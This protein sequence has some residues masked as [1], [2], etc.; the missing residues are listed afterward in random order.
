M[1]KIKPSQKRK[2]KKPVSHSNILMINKCKNEIKN[3]TANPSTL[4]NFANELNQIGDVRGALKIYK[5]GLK[6][7]PNDNAAL[8]NIALILIALF[9]FA[10]AIIY[11]T[12]A[13]T[14]T[15]QQFIAYIYRSIAYLGERKKAEAYADF[16]FVYDNYRDK[17][18]HFTKLDKNSF[19]QIDFDE[20]ME[21]CQYPAAVFRPLNT[22]YFPTVD[23]PV[24]E[25][26]LFKDYCQQ[27]EVCPQNDMALL[28]DII[29]RENLSHP[30][31]HHRETV[32]LDIDE[33][34][35]RRDT[36]LHG[37]E[38]ETA[39]RDAILHGIDAE[40]AHREAIL[41]GIDAEMAKSVSVKFLIIPLR[42]INFRKPFQYILNRIINFRK[43]FQY[44]LNLKHR[45]TAIFSNIFLL[46][47]LPLIE[48]MLECEAIIN[49]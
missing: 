23:C 28:E 17:I 47:I 38:A 26:C 27:K 8:I 33:V 12:K 7:S 22:S 4:F 11:L 32:L 45:L 9:D 44:I 31:D 46:L 34:M 6:R 14:H 20:A 25:I 18:H 42:L 24:D 16:K 13:I 41:H 29:L 2:S 30:R 35:D 5:K 19:P 43:P 21:Y 10:Q 40:T 49:I 15:P 36:I 37:I 1:S 48:I 3:H 39:H